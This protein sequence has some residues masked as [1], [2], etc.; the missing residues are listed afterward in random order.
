MNLFID[1]LIFAKQNAGGISRMWF[2]L[3]K[4]LPHD[5]VD[6]S[7]FIPLFHNNVWLKNILR[8]KVEIKRKSDL[9]FWPESVFQRNAVRSLTLPFR[10]G[11]S[12]DIFHSTF[13]STVYKKSVKK[14]VTVHDMIPEKFPGFVRKSWQKMERAKKKAALQNADMIITVSQN[15]KK[16]LIT[17]YPW[18]SEKKIRVIYH[19]PF[20]V[21]NKISLDNIAK[22]YSL[23]L[24]PQDYFLYVG[25]R[26][27]YKNFQILISLVENK[28]RYQ[29]TVFCCVGGGGS[30]QPYETL[31]AKG[32]DR[33]FQF[34][35]SVSDDELASL[36]R[37]ARALL[38]PSMY[39]GFGLP[40]LE[41]LAHECPVICGHVSSL[42]E[43]AK[44][45][46]FYFDPSSMESLDEAIERLSSADR[47]EV[48]NAGKQAVSNF[49][50]EKAAREIKD[51]Y[52]SLL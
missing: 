18:I 21:E 19:G 40:V 8:E 14:I 5:D 33:N 25:R 16:D 51:V 26:K 24:V 1:G 38:F 4:R 7:L 10:M 17:I 31:A 11:H 23:N 46:A 15:T 9:F 32:L 44:D 45:A 48:V 47:D 43:I 20:H 22:K 34:V 49:S 50:W 12:I 28:A 35:P 37:N 6:I 2:E 52:L 29:D 13:F 27:N 39:E 30:D 42:P 36:Y 41:A 3:L